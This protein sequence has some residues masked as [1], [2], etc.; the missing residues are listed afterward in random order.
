MNTVSNYYELA[1]I[2][3]LGALQPVLEITVNSRVAA[4]YNVIA[5]GIVL[6][7]SVWRIRQ[8]PDILRDWGVR[9]DTFIDCL[10]PYLAFTAVGAGAVYGYGMYVGTTPL[11]VSFWYLFALYPLWG[12]AQQFVLQNWLARNLV[13]MVPNL[14]ARSLIVALFFSLAHAPSIELMTVTLIG[15]F[16]FTLLYRRYPNLLALGIAHGI[17]GALVFYLVL[18]QD[19]WEILKGYFS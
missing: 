19:Q 3:T 16:F 15:G 5:V 12:F 14:L 10:L 18:G 11:P 9:L 6:S 13:N 1:L 8:R 2:L 4:L 7:Y 17:L